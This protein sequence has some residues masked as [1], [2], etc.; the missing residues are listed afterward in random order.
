MG[1]FLE[2]RAGASHVVDEEGST[3]SSTESSAEQGQGHKPPQG[4]P[5]AGAEGADSDVDV[6]SGGPGAAALR[7]QHSDSHVAPAGMK[8]PTSPPA[9][10]SGHGASSP[11]GFAELA[12]LAEAAENNSPSGSDQDVALSRRGSSS[13]D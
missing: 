7:V 1:S 3:A 9:G 2:R 8:P 6:T 11:Q 4:L 10:F 5:Q 12:V 13:Q